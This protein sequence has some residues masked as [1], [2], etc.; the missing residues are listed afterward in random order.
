MEIVASKFVICNDISRPEYNEIVLS[1][2]SEAGY[3]PSKHVYLARGS[4]TLKIHR[5]NMVQWRIQNSE[6]GGGGGGED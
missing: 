3:L 6:G 1:V 5:A 2:E 4:D